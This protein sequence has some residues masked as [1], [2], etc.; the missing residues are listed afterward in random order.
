MIL[1]SPQRLLT[2]CIVLASFEVVKS[3]KSID[4]KVSEFNNAELHRRFPSHP[5]PIKD[6]LQVFTKTGAA[7]LKSRL[8]AAYTDSK[9][10]GKSLDQ[11]FQQA[12]FREIHQC[13]GILAPFLEK[14]KCYHKIKSKSGGVRTSPCTFQNIRPVIQFEL[15]K[16][17]ARL[18]LSAIIKLGSLSFPLEE[19]NRSHFLLEK[20]DVYHLL[21]YK[22]YQT[23][24]WLN[25]KPVAEAGRDEIEFRKTVLSKLEENY[26]V[27]RN[28]LLE[29][30][31]ISSRPESQVMVNELNG[32]FLMLTPQ[33]LYEGFLLEGNFKEHSEIL[34]NGESY[35]IQR[36]HEA[37]EWLRNLLKSLH[38][39]FEKQSQG[40]FF[41][42]FE[43]ARQKN[44]FL[45]AY[46][47]LLE[48]GIRVTGMDLL[49]NFR[50][51]E[52]K[53]ATE[54]EISNGEGEHELRLVMRVTFGD[55]TIPLLTIQGITLSGQHTLLLADDSL[56]VLDEAWQHKYGDI[57]RHGRIKD[58]EI[59]IERWIAITEQHES[60]A[61][62]LLKPVLANDWWGLWDRWQANDELVFELPGV[63]RV[64]KLR[65]Y[66]QR[67]FEWLVLL[68]R[69]S[70]GACLADDMGLGK[71]LQTICFLAR[72]LEQFP[73]M[74]HL[75]VCPAS[76]VY[77]WQQE[78]EKFAPGLRL[79]L[80]YGNG[81]NADDLQKDDVDIVITSL[82][83]L[84]SDIDLLENI[85]FCVAVV[86]E[87]HHIKNP[88]ALITRA[89]NRI[90]AV[91]RVALSGTPVMN[92]TFDL[93]A[94][95]NFVV[96]GMFGSREFFKRVYAD[97]IDRDHDPVKIK[98]LQKL[99]AP[100]ILRRTKEQVAPDLPKKTEL[101]L[102]C[103]MG[104]QQR[105]QYDEVLGQIRS[106]I[107]L[108]I[109]RDG[110]ERSKLSIIQGIMKLRQ[111]CN[112]P[113]LLPNED[114]FCDDSVKTEVLMDE[115]LNNLKG[116]KVLVF[117]QFSKM[118]VL[119]A[120]QLEEQ[121]LDFFHFDGQ[122][123]PKQRMEMV[124]RFQE[125]GNTTDIFLIS[126]M[127]G[128]MGLNLTAADYVF[129]FDP[130]WNT[131][132]QQQAIDRTH[133]IGQTKKVFAYKMICRDT[134]EEK[135]LHLQERKRHLSDSLIGG[136]D[137]FVKSLSMEDLEYLLK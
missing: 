96:P 68:A 134:I 9:H 51:S 103:D 115:L 130:W 10:L 65:P 97:P 122:T 22:D 26:K 75:V 114:F 8:N 88:Y 70:A 30:N 23:L 121:K 135:I 46:H 15:K 4:Y 3:A 24:E 78:F 18:S 5:K 16:K 76:L 11:Y 34:Q 129:L 104:M 87:S 50:F 21:G 59:R 35:A 20:D 98:A 42:S 112:S 17:A 49:Q 111:V 14:T 127:A 44:W 2:D 105:D 32:T 54:M 25:S 125:E 124:N 72:Q 100:F 102:W 56:G 126:L 107:F 27:N 6:V 47:H 117:S 60:P 128:N 82:G 106:S 109:A 84:R 39:A 83:T 86:D 61:S 38:P 43:D 85:P 116:H 93:H 29:S 90:R 33:W 73:G 136:E 36:D 99:T 64:E 63:I 71:T 62:Q 37:E 110:F 123:A 28:G 133:R 45:K 94:Q 113:L 120:K 7:A 131:A 74:K 132:V 52:H 53:A 95:L 89:V 101:V 55:E 77:N 31:N 91:T 81:R 118:L 108:E 67:G 58:N 40:Y 13:I 137:G 19:L 1:L 79:H 92:N 69:I 66:Q 80:F 119:L 12:F 41:L 48:L 57:F